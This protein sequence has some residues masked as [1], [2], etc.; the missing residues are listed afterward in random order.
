MA[1]QHEY[2]CRNKR[3]GN[4]DREVGEIHNVNADKG[5]VRVLGGERIQII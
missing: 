3:S 1:F 2:G 4:G 5:K